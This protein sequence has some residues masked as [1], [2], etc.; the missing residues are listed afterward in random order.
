MNNDFV[1]VVALVREN[2]A[3]GH[4]GSAVFGDGV[5]V[6]FRPFGKVLKE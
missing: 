2:L 6:V 1:N 4:F 3:Q 5:T